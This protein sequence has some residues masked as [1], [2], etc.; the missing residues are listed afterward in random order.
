M[1]DFCL[2]IF[3][4]YDFSLSV[5]VSSLVSDVTADLDDLL[6]TSQRIW[7]YSAQPLLLLSEMKAS[8]PQKTLQPTID[9]VTGRFIGIEEV[10]FGSLRTLSNDNKILT[11]F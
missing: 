2:C 8:K 11:I 7:H 5:E 10:N 9:L 3:Y 6:P 1:K 4:H